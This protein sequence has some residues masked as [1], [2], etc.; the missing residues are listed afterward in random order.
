LEQVQTTEL[1]REIDAPRTVVHAPRD[2]EPA[3]KELL[4]EGCGYSLIGL[5]H[6]RLCPECGKP[7]NPDRPPLARV[8]WLYRIQSGPVK[9]YVETVRVILKDPA[10]FAAELS[11]PARISLRDAMAFRRTTG[12]ITA[13]SVAA[14]VTSFAMLPS[15]RWPQSILVFC[16][17]AGMVIGM[18]CFVHFATDM[19]SFIWPPTD[20]TKPRQLSPLQNYASAPMPLMIL[21]LA[22]LTIGIF[23]INLLPG[24]PAFMAIA[25][26]SLASLCLIWL[27][28]QLCRVNAAF[29]RISTK[30]PDRRCRILALYLPLH[31]LMIAIVSV[32]ISALVAGMIM[33]IVV[34]VMQIASYFK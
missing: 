27:I 28:F 11:R 5:A 25:I 26:F 6:T 12:W 33:S 29:M 23:W 10:A 31:Y 21:P 32:F 17:A 3:A 8:P 34:F 20:R 2:C 7:F 9:A 18:R 19:P 24:A 16:Y 14:L 13:I 22:L 1:Q 15:I 30:C 4:C